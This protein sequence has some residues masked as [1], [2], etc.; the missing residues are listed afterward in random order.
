MSV[1]TQDFQPVPKEDLVHL[2]TDPVPAG[3]YYKAQYFELE[4]E[5]IFK[6]TCNSAHNFGC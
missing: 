4:R 6:R 2:G 5:A 3:P 1:R